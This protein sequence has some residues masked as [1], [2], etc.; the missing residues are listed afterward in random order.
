MLALN[1]LD[2]AY[3]YLEI[4]RPR[5]AIRHAARALDL[6][7]HF[8]DEANVKNSLYLLGEA[9]HLHGD[10]AEARR[11]FEQLAD[12]YDNLPFIADFLLSVDVR[13]MINLRA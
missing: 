6:A 7:R 10:D 5:P 4:R 2:L 3:A 11:H 8:K 9:W 13:Q 12:R 1:H